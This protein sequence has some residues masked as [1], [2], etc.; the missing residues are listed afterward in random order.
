MI[1]IELTQ[2]E[3]SII[4]LALI[5]GAIADIASAVRGQAYPLQMQSAFN[6]W[7]QA[8]KVFEKLPLSP[9]FVWPSWP[10]ELKT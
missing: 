9:G 4:K 1:R 7:D 2:G 3:L 6:A 10:E 5:E 8:R